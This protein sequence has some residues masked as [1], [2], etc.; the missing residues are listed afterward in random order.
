MKAPR[1][2]KST[3]PDT[4][5]MAP[6]T[7]GQ[8]RETKRPIKFRF[9]VADRVLFTPSTPGEVIRVSQL[10]TFITYV[11]LAALQD[12]LKHCLYNVKK[13]SIRQGGAVNEDEGKRKPKG[14]RFLSPP[15]PPPWGRRLY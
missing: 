14:K 5:F 13:S 2:L 4:W 11:R 10:S 3:A 1:V 15:G 12:L 6:R 9:P 8:R 7:K